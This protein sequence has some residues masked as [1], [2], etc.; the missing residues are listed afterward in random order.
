MNIIQ[1]PTLEHAFQK[2]RLAFFCYSHETQ[3]GSYV[4]I[5]E[6]AE[7]SFIMGEFTP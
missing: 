6:R 1:I 3:L 4:F 2:F 7:G 5:S